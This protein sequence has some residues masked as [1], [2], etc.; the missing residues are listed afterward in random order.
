M[1]A[2]F[3]CEKIEWALSRMLFTVVDL[4]GKDPSFRQLFA[5]QEMLCLPHLEKLLCVGADKLSKKEYPA[6]EKAAMALAAKKL[7]EVSEDVS[8]FCRMFD[9]RNAGGDWG[10]SRDSI[11]R[12]ICLLGNC[13]F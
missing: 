4:Y 2:C 13:G 3:V 11:E 12:A 9:Y 6:F 10:N 7:E 8:H 5:E 1:R